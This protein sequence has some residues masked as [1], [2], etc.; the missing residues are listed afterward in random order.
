MGSNLGRLLRYARGQENEQ[1]E[2]FTTEALAAAVREDPAPLL[3]ALQRLYEARGDQEAQALLPARLQLDVAT[4][5]TLD[6]GRRIDFRAICKEP[7]LQIWIEVKVHSGESGESQLSDY[8][9]EARKHPPSRVVLLGRED[10]RPDLQDLAFLSWQ[11]LYDAVTPEFAQHSTW[12]RELKHFLK[13]LRMADSYEIPVTAEELTA[14]SHWRA[15]FGKVR[16]I[17]QPVAEHLEKLQPSSDWPNKD[18]ELSRQLNEMF[19]RWNVLMMY[20]KRPDGWGLNVGVVSR[21]VGDGPVEPCLGMAIWVEKDPKKHE[22]MRA[23]CASLPAPWRRKE[24][25]L[26]E[27]SRPLREFTANHHQDAIDFLKARAN[28][29]KAANI[30]AL[31]SR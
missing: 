15:L 31:L 8:L 28:E 24:D 27:V 17:L 5:V 20:N 18:G 12:W 4:Q 14:F 6:S 22:A 2:N 19:E 26:C 21:V 16:R 1:T 23:A 30:L 29:L 11:A 9:H 3:A 25:G 7:S 13:E 10:L